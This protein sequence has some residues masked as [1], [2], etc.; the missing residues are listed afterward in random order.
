MVRTSAEIL[1]GVVTIGLD[2][3]PEITLYSIKL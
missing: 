3:D 2:T 1:K